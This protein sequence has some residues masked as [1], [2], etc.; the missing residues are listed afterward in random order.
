[1]NY[2]VPVPLKE[3]EKTSPCQ[4]SSENENQEMKSLSGLVK[5][6][7]G[8]AAAER[9]KRRIPC[10][11]SSENENQEMKSLSGLVKC[12]PRLVAKNASVPIFDSRTI[13]LAP[14]ADASP[15]NLRF[16]SFSRNHSIPN[17]NNSVIFVV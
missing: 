2:L 3:R 5:F 14:K 17:F 16:S 4:V 1:M 10:Q 15:Y 7:P 8:A 12:L 11:V 9:E 6:L 13:S